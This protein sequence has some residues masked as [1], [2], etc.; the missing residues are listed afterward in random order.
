M[1]GG[2]GHRGRVTGDGGAFAG[3]CGDQQAGGER[4]AR[5]A[6]EPEPGGDVAVLHGQPST[7]RPGDPRGH[8]A[9]AVPL[10]FGPGTGIGRYAGP[11][12]PVGVAEGVLTVGL[13]GYLGDVGDPGALGHLYGAFGEPGGLT[14]LRPSN[15]SFGGPVLG[16]VSRPPRPLQRTLTAPPLTP[17]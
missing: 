1:G 16:R 5:P 11:R 10:G 12:Q 3:E 7:V 15:L 14:P 9:G 4:R 17:R 8:G 13:P 2:A 6:P